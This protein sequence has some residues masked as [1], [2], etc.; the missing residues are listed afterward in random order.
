MTLTNLKY[1]HFIGIGGIGMSA[2]ARYF[3]ERGIK[4]SGYDKTKTVLTSELENEGIFVYDENTPHYKFGVPDLIIY[5]PAVPI[6][7]AEFDVAR[8]EGI[9]LYKRSEVLGEI[10]KSFKTVAVAGTHGKTT[11]TG[12]LTSLALQLK[13][14]FT[15]F[16]GGVLPELN[17]NYIHRGDE[18]LI[19]E[20]DEFDKSFLTLRPD[21]IIINSMDADHL[22]IYKDAN[23][24]E[25]NY[26]EFLS[27]LKTGGVLIVRDE[28]KSKVVKA[29]HKKDIWSFGDSEEADFRL[30]NI[31]PDDGK[32]KL[33]WS[34]QK[35]QYESHLSMPGRHNA[36]NALGA[37]GAA[38]AVGNKPEEVARQLGEFKGIHRRFEIVFKNEE[39]VIIDDYAH[40]P[41]EIKAAVA[42]AKWMFPGRRL[43][44]VFQSHL[45]SRTR[46]FMDQF[47]EELSKLD[48]LFTCELYPAREQPIEGVSGRDLFDRVK[49]EKKYY[50]PKSEIASE[51]RPVKDDV[52]LVMGAGNIDSIIPELIEKIER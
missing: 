22:D 39:V 2:L 16:V 32:M 28:L 1:V 3:N 42:A 9:K 50:L 10:S 15:A 21:V 51:I 17:G 31:I 12:I 19:T 14:N 49:M 40:H 35:A 38:I 29:L 13:M 33:V 43:I 23:D 7:H 47:A 36:Y 34:F 4:V 18:W 5:T 44:G 41:T 25:N 48:L 24:L 30:L 11:T 8:S 20:A 27:Q 46:D 6:S 37:M 45:Y 52:V 26:I